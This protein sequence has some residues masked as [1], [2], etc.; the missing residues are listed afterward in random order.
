VTETACAPI[1][2]SCGP[3]IGFLPE[4]FAAARISTGQMRAVLPDRTS[5]VFGSERIQGG[6]A[7]SARI[8]GNLYRACQSRETAV[9]R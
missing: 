7:G 3:L 4:R 9:Q 5:F 6:A 2:N 1:L 8:A